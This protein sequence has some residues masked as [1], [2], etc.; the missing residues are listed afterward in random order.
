MR[1]VYEHKPSD[2]EEDFTVQNIYTQERLVE[3]IVRH[4][5]VHDYDDT[6]WTLICSILFDVLPSFC[7][8]LKS[9]L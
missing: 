1:N 2:P 4:L 9:L 5:L 7:Q 8:D 6:N 3:I